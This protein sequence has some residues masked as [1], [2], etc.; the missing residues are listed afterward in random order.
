M[1][2]DLYTKVVMTVIALSLFV[3]AIQLTTKEA[4]AQSGLR[5]SPSGALMVTICDPL[6]ALGVTGVGWTCAD[7]LNQGL[8]VAN[9]R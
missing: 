1:K 3:I 7:V 5:F 8:T 6:G 4:H 2:A 9:K